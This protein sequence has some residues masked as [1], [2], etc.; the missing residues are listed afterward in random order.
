MGTWGTGISSNDTFGDVYDQFFELYNEG[1]EPDEITKSLIT[2]NQETIQIPEDSNNFWFALAKAQWECNELDPK[3]LERVRTIVHTGADLE[4]WRELG[5]SE[6][7]IKKRKAALVKF[8]GKLES[9]RSKARSR[10]KV[11]IHVPVFEKGDCLTFELK[12]GCFG[13]ALVLEAIGGKGYAQNLIATL[14]LNQSTRP[15][16]REIASADVLV[17][18]FAIHQEKPWIM[19]FFD[20]TYKPGVEVLE[21]VGNLPIAQDF[22]AD[23]QFGYVGGWKHWMIDPVNQQFD[24]ER[25]HSAPKKRVKAESFIKKKWKF[26]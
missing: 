20:G 10:K 26:W 7:D 22:E 8:L 14:R 18:N 9:N 17:A 13:G 5:A 3:L 23:S 1:A 2:K 15:T 11:E 19:W 6:I 4:V 21:V 12:D 16:P 24:H 25:T